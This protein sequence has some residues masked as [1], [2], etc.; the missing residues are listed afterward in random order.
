M[1]YVGLGDVAIW[2]RVGGKFDESYKYVSGEYKL[3]L[4]KRNVKYGGLRKMVAEILIVEVSVRKMQFKFETRHP[5]KPLYGVINERTFDLFMHHAWQDST[6][7]SLY[8]TL[9]E[10][11]FRY[12]GMRYTGP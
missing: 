6:M 1:L 10:E 4:G 5:I 7:Y 2:I 11:S 12:G 8:V 3:L 9:E